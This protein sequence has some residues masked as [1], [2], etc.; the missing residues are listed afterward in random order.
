MKL[1]NKVALITGGGTG[2][3]RQTSL[4]FANEGA[5]IAVNYSRS[6]ADA[7]DTVSQIRDQGGSAIAVKA[8][9]SRDAE[10]RA[11]VDRIVS[12]LG[13]LDIL[14]NNAGVTRKVAHGDME[15]LTEQDWDHALGVNLK[16]AFF[17]SRAAAPHMAN[18]GSGVIVNNSS[19]AAFHGSGSSIAYGASKAGV[20]YLTQSLARALAPTI[21][22]N[23]IAPGYVDTRWT[24]PW[25][26]FRSAHEQAT[27]L[28]RV[29]D[30]KEIAEVTLFLTADARFITGQTI[31]VDGGKLLTSVG[32]RESW[33]ARAGVS[34]Q[35]E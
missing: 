29:A 9:I 28:K 22:V 26:E 4:L 12:E 32:G 11:M 21:R 20:I 15:E 19:I 1:K 10:V 25:A 8:D 30:P 14:I 17:C 31:V 24:A 7:N 34:A 3:G 6:E 18:A 16:G 2:I 5:A 27:P 33:A 13:G 35:A 23:A